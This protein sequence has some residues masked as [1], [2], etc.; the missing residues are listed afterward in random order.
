M[1]YIISTSKQALAYIDRNMPRLSDSHKQLTERMYFLLNLGS[2]KELNS[3]LELETVTVV[4]YMC[5]AFCLLVNFSM[6]I[7]HMLYVRS[8]QFPD[9]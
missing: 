8:L 1:N 3:L 2:R 9:G 6:F 7:S 4:T 5:L